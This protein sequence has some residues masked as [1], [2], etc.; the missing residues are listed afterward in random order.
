MRIATQ[1]KVCII[2]PDIVGPI[3]NGGIGTH[4]FYLA[5]FLSQELKY[6]AYILFTS[7]FFEN[8]SLKFWKHYYLEKLGVKFYHISE[9]RIYD[10]SKFCSG[11][12]NYVTHKS[13]TVYSWLKNNKFDICHFQEWKANG[14]V[15][16]QAKRTGLA[17]HETILTCMMHSSSEWIREGMQRFPDPNKDHLILDYAERYCVEFADYIISPSQYM[18]QWANCKQWS[19]G[20]QQKILPYLLETN[21]Y[22]S[23]SK[24]K[25][26][27]A[28]KHIIFFGRLDTRKGIEIFIESLNQLE[29]QWD[30]SQAKLPIKITFLGKIG[31]TKYGDAEKFIKRNLFGS[32]LFRFKIIKNYGHEQ[33]LSFL[34]QNRN[35]LVVTPS[36]VD[37]LPF[38][39]LE[40]VELDLNIIA[41]DTGGIPEIFADKMRLFELKSSSLCA[42]LKEFLFIEGEIKLNKK[43]SS[44]Q[45]ER[46]WK[47]FH[48]EL[49]KELQNNQSKNI[50][51]GVNTVKSDVNFG[52]EYTKTPCI[53]VCIPY[54]NYGKHLPQLLKSLEQQTFQ[55]FE[56]I[57][58]NDGST[59]TESNHIFETMKQQYK[60]PKWKFI[61]QPNSGAGKARNFAA[62]HSTNSS[63]YLVFIDADNIANP[64]ML[65]KM[66]KGIKVSGTDCLTCYFQAFQKE[67]DI[68]SGD[69]KFFYT[70]IGG[71][72]EA[73]IYDNVLGD[74]NFI[75]NKEI[76]FKVG[77]FSELCLRPAAEDWK[78]LITL[79]LEGYSLDVIPDF[80]LKYRL[81]NLHKNTYLRHLRALEPYLNRMPLWQQRLTID[82]VGRM[83]YVLPASGI[84]LT[85]DELGISSSLFNRMRNIYL[86]LSGGGISNPNPGLLAKILIFLKRI[87]SKLVIR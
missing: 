13:L 4:C 7:D 50:N 57:V 21:Q 72:L 22:K 47:N 82:A 60:K 23:S 80:L 45:A 38:A 9:I 39:V 46:T 70:P 58:V 43:Y 40:C 77:G 52:T 3:N 71:C 87:I 15:S 81:S 32:Q 28:K 29:L 48:I 42:K 73:G 69:W 35:A 30:N 2:T 79:L 37:N 11:K 19:L 33:A 1:P 64:N 27:N 49:E 54:F 18:L 78:F 10:Y 8:K 75:I 31:K 51:I 6:D 14:F 16:I 62:M 85:P 74:A 12:G 36:L 17:F 5:K 63:Q 20:K 66:Y 67:S 34:N 86:Q 44:K 68:S 26:K 55:D 65:E 25:P 53:T 41:G 84:S 83:Y 24:F 76:F 56:A 61:D 59:D